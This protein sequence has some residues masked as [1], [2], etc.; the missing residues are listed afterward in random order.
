MPNPL[1]IFGRKR[2]RRSVLKTLHATLVSVLVLQS[3]FIGGFAFS[4]PAQ[5]ATGDQSTPPGNSG[6]IWTTTGAC[7][8]DIQDK[9]HY[10][11]GQHVFINAANFVPNTSYEW[12]IIGQPGQASTK[13]NITVASGAH[14]TNADG[15][16][17]FDA[18]TIANDDGGEFQATF[19]NKHDNYRVDLKDPCDLS[20]DLVA[21]TEHPCPDPCDDNKNTSRSSSENS[22]KPCPDPCD[23]KAVATSTT[24]PKPD[25]CPK[26]TTI[27]VVKSIGQQENVPGWSWK[28]D[29]GQSLPMGLYLSQ[30]VTPGQHTIT[31]IQQEGYVN[32]GWACYQNVTEGQRPLLGVDTGESFSL[33]IPASGATCYFNNMLKES[34]AGM[35]H[36]TKTDSYGNG[37]QNWQICYAEAT[38]YDKLSTKGE[39]PSTC[40]MTDTQGHYAFMDVPYGTYDVWE[41]QQTGWVPVMPANG[42]YVYQ[43]LS[44]KDPVLELNFQNRRLQANLSIQKD[45]D[46]TTVLP[47]QFVTYDIPVSNSGVGDALNTVV[48]DTLPA[49]VSYVSSTF[50]GAPASPSVIGS[51]VTWNIG[52]LAIGVTKMI[53]L[54]VQFDSTF[55]FGT[56]S[57]TN[58]VMVSTDTPE[59]TTEDNHAMDTDT[60]TTTSVLGLQKTGP[61]TV[62]A[63]DN[64]TYTLNWSVSGTAAVTQA[65]IS[66]PF[67]ANTTFV[68]QTCG[69]T[70]GICVVTQDASHIVWNLG[71]RAQGEHGTVTVTVKTSAA[72]AN[73]VILTNTGTF[74]SEETP[75]V[76]SSAVTTVLAKTIGSPILSITKSNNVSI[77]TN[78]GQ[79]VTYTVVVKNSALATASAVNVMMTDTLPAGFTFVDTG[80]STKVI[81]LGTIAPGNSVTLTYDV[82]VSTT[83]SSGNYINTASAKGENTEIVSASSTVAIRVPEVLGVTTEPSLTLTKSVN[84]TKAIPSGSI[85]TYTVTIKNTGD[86]VASNVVLEDTLPTG[87]TFLADGSSHKIWNLGTLKP[88]H[89]RVIIYDVKISNSVVNGVYKNVAVLTADD[90]PA[91]KAQASVT[92]KNPKVLGLATTGANPFDKLVL[93]LSGLA[94]LVGASLVIRN[95][96]GYRTS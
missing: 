87:F 39:T 47:G 86:Q 22:P 40:T 18:Y 52:T 62:N 4:R 42:Q 68:S 32:I 79:T 17:C 92:I 19:N 85:V 89:T 51:T 73:G 54:T 96:H 59:T 84:V 50:D 80:L 65:M 56:T 69:T 82:L 60:V 5:A 71:T 8:A 88:D 15:N 20:D 35:I 70:V 21:N 61:A 75:A 38:E 77:F 26:P 57:V 44:V 83:V 76:Q 91:L 72:L 93:A 48:T 41:T 74:D 94:F 7:G 34:K 29:N 66:D 58:H 3:V 13:P 31:E 37:L 36:G 95:Q 16:V 64:M 24:T 49:H 9:N 12:T 23:D 11:V 27:T 6:A 30:P 78:P 67:P 25:N 14:L 45:D 1:R 53:R 43:S 2:F 55:P 33:N 90:Q 63:G 46:R 10:K 81:A 28:L